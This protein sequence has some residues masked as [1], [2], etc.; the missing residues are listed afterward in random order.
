[1]HNGDYRSKLVPFAAQKNILYIKKGPSLERFMPL[2]VLFT[3]ATFVC[4]TVCDSDRRH[5]LK[6]LALSTLGSALTEVSEKVFTLWR[7]S[8]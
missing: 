2:S 8:L 6:L 4:E 1:L 3:L 7:K 5:H